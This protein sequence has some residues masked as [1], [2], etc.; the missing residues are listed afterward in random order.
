MWDLLRHSRD[1][2]A[3]SA[4]PEIFLRAKFRASAAR[5][6]SVRRNRRGEKSGRESPEVHGATKAQ[7]SGER[8]PGRASPLGITNIPRH[9][10]HGTVARGAGVSPASLQRS[11]AMS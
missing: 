11:P 8:T 1:A 6:E 7:T 4:R 3:D 10:A 9:S 5:E 2:K